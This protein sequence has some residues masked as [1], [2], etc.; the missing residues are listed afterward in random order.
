MGWIPCAPS[1]VL[2]DLVMGNIPLWQREVVR[3]LGHFV[4][5]LE[6]IKGLVIA[7]SVQ[8]KE[9]RANL[10]SMRLLP[11]VWHNA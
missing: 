2:L 3:R 9:D 5:A 6:L 8:R 1:T 11:L 10:R 7:G 4:I